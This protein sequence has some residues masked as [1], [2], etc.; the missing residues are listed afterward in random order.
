MQTALLQMGASCLAS[1]DSYSHR[2]WLLLVHEVNAQRYDYKTSR[3]ITMKIVLLYN[4]NAFFLP[5]KLF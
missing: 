4:W 2:T 3:H 5:W 1:L